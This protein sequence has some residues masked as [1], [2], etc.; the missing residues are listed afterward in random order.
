MPVLGIIGWQNSGKTTLVERLVQHFGETGL[1]VS[2]IKHA[3]HDVDVDQPGKD[4]WRHRQAGAVEV[5]L[6]TARRTMSIHELRGAPE[7]SLDA[8]VA[9]LR[10]VDLVLVEGFKSHDHPKLEVSRA[11][12]RQPLRAWDDPSVLAVASDY[13]P[14]GLHRPHFPLDDV[15]AIARFVRATVGR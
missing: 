8:L 14:E 4:S 2:T 6:A 1:R 10:P 11:A 9:R 13:L 15:A 7:P 12:T 3:H 5:V